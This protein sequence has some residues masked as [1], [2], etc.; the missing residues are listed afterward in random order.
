VGSVSL[1]VTYG[2]STKPLTVTAPI[3]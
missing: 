2:S 1:F 3:V